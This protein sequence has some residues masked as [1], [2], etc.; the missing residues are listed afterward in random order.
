MALP[1]TSDASHESVTS[2]EYIPHP[3]PHHPGLWEQRQSLS[4]TTTPIPASPTPLPPPPHHQREKEQEASVGN[5]SISSINEYERETISNKREKESNITRRDRDSNRWEKERSSSNKREKD[6]NNTRR[7]RD[8]NT[9]KRN[10]SSNSSCWLENKENLFIS[11]TNITSTTATST[12]SGKRSRKTIEGGS[13]NC[14]ILALSSPNLIQEDEDGDF[15]VFRGPGEYGDGE[16]TSGESPDLGIGSDHHY[17]SLERGTTISS[18]LAANYRHTYGSSGHSILPHQPPS[19]PTQLCSEP[20]EYYRK[21]FE[22]CSPLVFQS[23]A[24]SSLSNFIYQYMTKTA[25]FIF[26]HPCF[27]VLSLLLFLMLVCHYFTS[28]VFNEKVTIITSVW[29]IVVVAEPTVLWQYQ[30]INPKRIVIKVKE[31]S[32]KFHNSW[33][34]MKVYNYQ[35]FLT[36]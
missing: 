7:E 15:D 14:G 16:T 19:L 34:C 22:S 21:S 26:L 5:A 3:A 23:I 36:A 2:L 18:A 31:Y 20:S 35:G 13:G 12:F 33:N 1:A 17:S 11:T 24:L 6:T 30:T 25:I 32:S 9:N 10:H 27:P 4:P 29:V 28:I 8:F